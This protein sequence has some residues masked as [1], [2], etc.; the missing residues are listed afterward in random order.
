MCDYVRHEVYTHLT[1]VYVSVCVCVCVASKMFRLLFGREFRLSELC[2]VW[3]ALLADSHDTGTLELV[4]YL[5][6]SILVYHRRQS[7]WPQRRQ[8]EW[9]QSRDGGSELYRAGWYVTG[10]GRALCYRI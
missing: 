4:P 9:P 7:E 3:D 6:C 8:S 2:S 10:P 1:R 5:F